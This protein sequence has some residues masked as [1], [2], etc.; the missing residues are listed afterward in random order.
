[1]D[2]TDW[3]EFQELLRGAEGALLSGQLNE[4]QHATTSSFHVLATA[5][6]DL[7]TRL[8]GMGAYPPSDQPELDGTEVE[9]DI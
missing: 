7:N 5:I 1:M 8:T 2:L 3:L 4:W 9:I 6:L